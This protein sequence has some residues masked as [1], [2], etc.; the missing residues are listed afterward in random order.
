MARFVLARLF[1]SALLFFAVTLFVFVVFFVIPQPRVRGPGQG[2]TA[3]S[4][5]IRDSIH[6]HGTM[7]Q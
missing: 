2:E 7:W 5:S 4:L 6:L 3:E 1:S